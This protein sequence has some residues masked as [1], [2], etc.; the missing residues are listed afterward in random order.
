MFR[1]CLKQEGCGL[2]RSRMSFPGSRRLQKRGFNLVELLIV[3]AII[4]ILAGLLFPALSK[5]RNATNKIVCLNNLKEI[6][7]GISMYLMDNNEYFFHAY[8]PI[9]GYTWYNCTKGESYFARDYLQMNDTIPA[10]NVK[11]THTL[12]DCP[13]NK[14]G[15]YYTSGYHIDYGWNFEL[16]GDVSRGTKKIGIISNPSTMVTFL[17]VYDNF[18]ISTTGNYWNISTTYCHS[19][20][21]DYLFADG[22]ASW[23]KADYFTNANFKQ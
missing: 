19:N 11:A 6:G 3:I 7:S 10:K 8:L 17:D 20:G 9:G 13:L 22:H 4:F 5:A 1:D 16:G 23:Q 14:T 2:V 12:L 18:W 15:A 21:A